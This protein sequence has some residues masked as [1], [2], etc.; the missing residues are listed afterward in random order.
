MWNTYSENKCN[1]QYALSAHCT[2]SVMQLDC[3]KVERYSSNE[4]ISVRM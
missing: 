2:V 3:L 1:V 4:Q